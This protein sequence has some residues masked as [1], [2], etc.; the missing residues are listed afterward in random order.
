MQP[1]ATN[2]L[3]L[4]IHKSLFLSLVEMFEAT[5]LSGDLHN[6]E[7]FAAQ[8]L[9]SAVADFRLNH[10]NDSSFTPKGDAAPI[11]PS[12]DSWRKK[13]GGIKIQRILHALDQNI[14]ISA[15]AERNGISRSTIRRIEQS[16]VQSVP[17]AAHARHGQRW[18]SSGSRRV[19]S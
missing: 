14:S 18:G 8:L 10:I 17:N 6:L 16:R 12:S 5:R 2:Q 15:I 4:K 11:P 13:V 1:F 7:S 19:Q 3:R 9:E